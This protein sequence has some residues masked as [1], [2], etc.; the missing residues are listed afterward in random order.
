MLR[1]AIAAV[2]TTGFKKS[3]SRTSC[4]GARGVQGAFSPLATRR[5]CFS[6]PPHARRRGSWGA[7]VAARPAAAVGR[8]SPKKYCE[9]GWTAFLDFLPRRRLTLPG[10]FYGT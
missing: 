10:A 9:A 2:D 4:R 6:S 3:P 5:N 8:E 7:G 1:A